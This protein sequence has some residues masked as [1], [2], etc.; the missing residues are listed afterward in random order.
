MGRR[1]LGRLCFLSFQEGH[2][3][4][5]GDKTRTAASSRTPRPR[6][7]PVRPGHVPGAVKD[8]AR[9]DWKRRQHMRTTQ[10]P[11]RSPAP[12]SRPSAD[13]GSGCDEAGLRPYRHLA[14]RV[15]ARALLDLANPAG[16]AADRESARMFLAGSCMLFH[17][18]RVAEI[19][20]WCIVQRAEKLD[21]SFPIAMC[22]DSADR[23]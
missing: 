10:L 19:N 11:T 21:S 12:I 3:L 7:R 6:S 18:C 13:D 22:R 2:E 20:P 17:W 4:N 16:S 14:V 5:S 15:L 8:G 23:G 1:V 9:R